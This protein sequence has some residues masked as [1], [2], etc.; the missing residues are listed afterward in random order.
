MRFWAQS[1]IQTSLEKNHCKGIT[2][3]EKIF[4]KIK[5]K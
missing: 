5:S 4:H 3:P 1:K 2:H